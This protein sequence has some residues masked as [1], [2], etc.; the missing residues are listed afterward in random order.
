ME[1]VKTLDHSREELSGVWGVER[2]EGDDGNWRGPPRPDD[3]RSCRRS[4]E[5]YNRLRREVGIEPS[6]RRRRS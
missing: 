4:V 1:A 6:G 5:P 3:L 2:T